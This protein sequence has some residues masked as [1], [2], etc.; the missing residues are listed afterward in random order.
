MDAVEGLARTHP[1]KFVLPPLQ[2]PAKPW[3]G[4]HNLAA[5]IQDDRR[6]GKGVQQLL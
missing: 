5:F 3:V 6:R 1:Q 2:E 4:R